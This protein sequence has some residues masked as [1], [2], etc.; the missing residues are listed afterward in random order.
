[1]TREPQG[2]A[3]ALGGT[4]EGRQSVARAEAVGRRVLPRRYAVECGLKACVLRFVED[5]GLIFGQKDGLKRLAD[6]WTHDLEK[7]VGIANLS[8]GLKQARQQRTKFDDYWAAV[9]KWNEVS[10]YATKSESEARELFEAITNP[11][12]GVMK[13]IR[14]HW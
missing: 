9:K 3:S 6:C 10:R 2:T 4:G 13:W 12:D 7:L 8:E 14:S 5:T 11:D 1:V